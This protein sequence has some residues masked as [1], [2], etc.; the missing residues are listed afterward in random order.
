MGKPWS[1]LREGYKHPDLADDPEHDPF[2][3]A[4]MALA[5]VMA[6]KAD[7]HYPGFLWLCEA[8]HRQGVAY[9][10][11]PGLTGQW[12]YVIHIRELKSDPG[13]RSVL[14]A[15]GETLERF[16]LPRSG[17]GRSDF[18]AA[19]RTRPLSTRFSNGSI[20]G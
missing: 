13:L 15:C 14:R 2:K 1:A 9:V 8:D 12:K 16:K 6:V 20:P 11:I 10:S 18:Y 19:M 5:K 7:Q 4:D 17:I 3:G